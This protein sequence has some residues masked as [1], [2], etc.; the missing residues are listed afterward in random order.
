MEQ[1]LTKLDVTSYT[2][3]HLKLSHAKRGSTLVMP[4]STGCRT[5]LSNFEA[6]LDYRYV[7]DPTIMVSF[8]IV[9][10]ADNASLVAWTT[11]P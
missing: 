9:D 1:D 4:Y 2:R 3:C 7:S 10:D 8:P 6:E 11:T 5:A